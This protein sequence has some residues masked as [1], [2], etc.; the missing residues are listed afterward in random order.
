MSHRCSLEEVALRLGCP[1]SQISALCTGEA[2][3]YFLQCGMWSKI[4]AGSQALPVTECVSDL[5]RPFPLLLFFSQFLIRW[6][7]NNL[8]R[9]GMLWA[10]W[11]CTLLG[12]WHLSSVL[13]APIYWGT[14]WIPPAI[15]YPHPSCCKLTMPFKIS[16]RRGQYNCLIRFGAFW[17]LFFPRV[18]NMEWM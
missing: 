5:G 12:S 3:C 15:P 9:T 16:S 13:S 4:K 10:C 7:K 11:W 8:S 6:S 14:A 17:M 2:G 1:E 18:V